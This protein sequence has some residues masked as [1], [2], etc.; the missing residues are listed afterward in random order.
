MKSRLDFETLPEPR[1]ITL[2]LVVHDAGVPPKSAAA[3]VVANVRNVNDEAPVFKENSYEPYK[4][5]HLNELEAQ[6]R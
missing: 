4:K 1:R 5:K 3:I 2:D 6:S